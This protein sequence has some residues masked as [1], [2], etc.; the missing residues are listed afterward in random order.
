MMPPEFPGFPYEKRVKIGMVSPDSVIT[1]PGDHRT[2]GKFPDP[3]NIFNRL[4]LQLYLW[5][6]LRVRPQ[7]HYLKGTVFLIKEIERG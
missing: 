5:G 2:S 4:M 6:Y 3:E 1:N 7:W